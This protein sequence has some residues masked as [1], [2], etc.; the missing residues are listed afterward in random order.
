MIEY[1]EHDVLGKKERSLHGQ[2]VEVKISHR[3]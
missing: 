1:V 3:Y 2:I